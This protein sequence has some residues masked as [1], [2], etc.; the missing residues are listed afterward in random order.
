MASAG[1]W[2]AKLMIREIC[3]GFGAKVARIGILTVSLT[4]LFGCAARQLETADISQMSC[5]AQLAF[6][7][8]QI[9][10]HNL[11]NKEAAPV[12][13]FPFLRANRNSVLMGKQVGAAIAG[14]QAA[15]VLFADW[16]AQMR[17]LDR[18]A[19]ASEFRNRGD[20]SMSS[21]ARIEDCAD[22][23]AAQLDMADYQALSKSVFVPDDYLDFQRIAGFYPL[24][25]FAAHFGYEGWKRDN[26]G[27]F[28]LGPDALVGLGVWESYQLSGQNDGGA[29]TLAIEDIRKDA[30]GRL[31][32]TAVELE[33]IARA[34]AP[35]FR[36]RVQSDSD[37]IGHPSLSA[38]GAVAHVDIDRPTIFYRLGHTWFNDQWHPQIIY[39]VWFPE[40]PA[41]GMFDI[42]AG[43]LDALIWRVTL[44]E[45][46]A[47]LIA[48]TIHGCGCYHLFFPSPSLHRIEAPEDG[49][50]R[51]TA[52]SPAGAVAS[53]VLTRPILWIDA[54]S[55]YL[56]A[57]TA[58]DQY[59]AHHT[60]A[61]ALVAEQL[62]GSLAL[63]DGTGFASLYDEDGFV[64]GTERLERYI[65]WPLGIDK[66]G[67]MRQ[68][69]HHA[70]AF[71]GRRHFDE[72]EL[73]GRYF[74]L[75]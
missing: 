45:K 38:K 26:L 23:M 34:Y 52:E 6:A 24:T 59:E 46:G 47:P 12:A 30:F 4:G 41:Q 44:D 51:E 5:S 18:A 28:D 25:A 14:G 35:E 17:G 2:N 49:D 71:V 62:L 9:D 32:P 43:H 64:P 27:S 55:H 58:R 7:A 3:S 48:D 21:L 68:W 65:L 70:T 61:S 57:V 13:A 1:V 15:D 69:G 36:V 67:A 60:V 73:L 11:R 16:V 20:A 8:S 39:T 10:K 19:R 66:P 72:P 37:R 53:S 40:R 75:K 56:M 50:I 54:V 31:V 29:A 33:N 63:G 74:D 42:L 22:Q